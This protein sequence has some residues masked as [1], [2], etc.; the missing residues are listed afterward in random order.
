MY[1]NIIKDK[2]KQQKAIKVLGLSFLQ[3]MMLTK[4]ASCMA[5]NFSRPRFF[6]RLLR[7]RLSA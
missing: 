1:K 7:R 2:T 6:R 5:R 4:K 3:S